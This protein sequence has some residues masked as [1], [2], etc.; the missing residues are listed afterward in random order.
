MIIRQSAIENRKLKAFTLIELLVV[1]AIISLLIS[2]LLP[3]LNRAKDLAKRVICLSNMRNCGTAIFTYTNDND[4][5]FPYRENW[6][7]LYRIPDTSDDNW[8]YVN[9]G[10]LVDGSYISEGL[11]RCPAYEGIEYS[12]W[13]DGS[14]Q[15]GGGFL[16]LDPYR[17]SVS[18]LRVTNM[19]NLYLR[20]P[21]NHQLADVSYPYG[22]ANVL[23][24]DY[25]IGYGGF[26]GGFYHGEEGLNAVLMDGSAH[27]MVD[28]RIYQLVDDAKDSGW[29]ARADAATQCWVVMGLGT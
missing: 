10:L 1:I 19:P 14:Q 11:L 7:K 24:S 22:P 18:E 3:S 17:S 4:E 20:E 25:M 8:E 27:W 15:L 13:G 21:A 16:Y 28:E 5:W 2:I 26:V 23:M 9:S 29:T 12:L 6:S